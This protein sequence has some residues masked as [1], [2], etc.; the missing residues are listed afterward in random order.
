MLLLQSIADLTLAAK[1]QSVSPMELCERVVD[2]DA[3]PSGI[4]PGLKKNIAAFVGVIRKLRRAA[5]RVRMSL[6]PGWGRLKVSLRP[7]RSR[8]C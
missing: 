6:P 4:K 3:L 1:L 8:I 5:E 7:H 2:G